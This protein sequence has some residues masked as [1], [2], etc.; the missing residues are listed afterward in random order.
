MGAKYAK[1]QRVRIIA[2]RDQHLKAKHPRIEECVSQTGVV[3]VSHWYGVSESYRPS[4]K[5]PHVV[6]HYIYD[7]CLDRDREIITAVPEYALQPLV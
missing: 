2:P 7:V 3:I 4:S 1:G 6:G 5:P